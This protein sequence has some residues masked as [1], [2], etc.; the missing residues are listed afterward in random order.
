MWKVDECAGG[1]QVEGKTSGQTSSSAG[2]R[3]EGQ[4]GSRAGGQAEGQAGGQAEGQAG[5]QLRCG[6]NGSS[7]NS[8]DPGLLS[9][10][11]ANAISLSTADS[12]ALSGNAFGASPFGASAFDACAPFSM[13]PLMGMVAPRDT[14]RAAVYL[15]L[16]SEDGDGGES[17]SIATQRNIVGDRARR[18]RGVQ[19][20][21]EFVDDGWS[22]STFERPAFRRMM[23]A[24]DAGAIDCI[25]VKDLSRFGRNY[26]ETGRYL[27]RELPA[28]GVRLVAVDD[29]YDSL[30]VQDMGAQ[31]I[32]P[33][34]NLIND[35]Y[36]ATTSAKVKAALAVRRRAGLYVGSK[37]PFGYV[38][39]PRDPARL[40]VDERAAEVVRRIFALRAQA[41]GFGEIA[42]RLNDD[43]VPS[44]AVFRGICTDNGTLF[45]MLDN[46]GKGTGGRCDDDR[47]DEGG[48]AIWHAC[49]VQRI[50]ENPCYAGVLTQGR[51]F[52]P[53][54]RSKERL[55]VP[56]RNWACVE[57]GC[58][59]IVEREAFELVTQLNAERAKLHGK[60]GSHPLGGLVVCGL[61]GARARHAQCVAG[62]RRYGYYRLCC[63]CGQDGGRRVEGAGEQVDGDRRVEEGGQRPVSDG[64]R[65]ESGG[66]RP[67][68]D[69]RRL[70][71][72]GQ[73]P[74]NSGRHPDDCGQWDEGGGKRP[75]G[76]GQRPVS[77]GRRPGSG[78]K[79][80]AAG[81][82]WHSRR[83]DDLLSFVCAQ[84]GCGESRA[85]VVR[86]VRQVRLFSDRDPEVE[87]RVL[88]AR[89]VAAG[90]LR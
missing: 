36:C 22:G 21:A 48:P 65:H 52:S 75:E 84:A 59:A 5:G 26:I 66:K 34:K 78:R 14:W 70:D 76:A 18:M 43:G 50:T 27:E 13:G 86:A 6:R 38:K 45:N 20:V 73:R 63:P 33:F 56:R 35:Y 49:E 25:L 89:S 37:A 88:G 82:C 58:P 3:A 71:S 47:P 80:R 19:V 79:R 9:V 29:G 15:R 69:G 54:F 30:Q 55:K 67:V 72:A 8:E 40:L 81:C 16:S 31:L 1:G 10:I 12:S 77:D 44:P 46:V 23:K 41:V 87:R 4:A 7:G 83:D 57:G 2:R 90:G 74:G 51:T 62:G 11:D 28:R 39:D 60:D 24:A 17:N 68:S 85:A 32:V 53:S 61:C 64:R 42:R